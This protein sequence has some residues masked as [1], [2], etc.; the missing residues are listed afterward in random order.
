METNTKLTE[1]AR[2]GL[3]D[4][5]HVHDSHGLCLC[6]GGG[7][8]CQMADV[9]AEPTSADRLGADP[10][11]RARLARRRLERA[12]ACVNACAGIPTP[13]GVRTMLEVVFEL[14]EAADE[15]DLDFAEVLEKARAAV[16]EMGYC[17]EEEA[18]AAELMGGDAE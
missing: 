17:A 18:V 12:A 1:S 16:L 6:A 8:A 15:D 4:P 11:P 7:H 2:M 10:K 5:W 13:E 3:K 9:V 14:A